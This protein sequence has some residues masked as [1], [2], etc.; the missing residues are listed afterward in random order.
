MESKVNAKIN[1]FEQKEEN[2]LYG[3]NDD[4]YVRN[5]DNKDDG[6]NDD[7]SFSKM[8]SQL[9]TNLSQHLININNSCNQ[10]NN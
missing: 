10:N 3:D 9:S 2:I 7:E 4:H 8:S 5:K 6:N 1:I